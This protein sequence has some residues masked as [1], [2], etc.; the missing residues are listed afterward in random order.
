M[1]FWLSKDCSY[2]DESDTNLMKRNDEVPA[3]KKPYLVS[4]YEVNS[5]A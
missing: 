2:A 3:L 5:A 4:G 1:F